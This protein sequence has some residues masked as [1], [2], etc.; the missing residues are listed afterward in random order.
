MLVPALC[1]GRSRGAL[2][3]AMRP[4]RTASIAL[5]SIYS[6]RPIGVLHSA[7]AGT[8]DVLTKL[9]QREV[10]QMTC[11]STGRPFQ[12]TQHLCAGEAC[13]T[14]CPVESTTSNR[15]DKT[16]RLI[17]CPMCT[18]SGRHAF[19]CFAAA[20][21]Y[22]SPACLLPPADCAQ[23]AMPLGVCAGGIKTKSLRPVL[24]Y[25]QVCQRCRT[26]SNLRE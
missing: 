21:E 25:R 26:E 15:A 2:C 19:S 11:N 4:A 13:C 16:R 3:G 24:R 8:V 10:D 7:R 1:C 6:A 9:F 12:R 22:L 17:F 5:S 18:C 20:R 14:I 23:K